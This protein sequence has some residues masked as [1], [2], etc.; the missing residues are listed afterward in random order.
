M[1]TY[2]FLKYVIGTYNQLDKPINFYLKKIKKIQFFVYTYILLNLSHL[3]FQMIGRLNT[4]LDKLE[5]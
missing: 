4:L 1:K 5:K 3:H 2:T